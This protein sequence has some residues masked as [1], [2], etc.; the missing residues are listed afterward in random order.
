M[1]GQRDTYCARTADVS[2]AYSDKHWWCRLTGFIP[3]GEI[4]AVHG[5]LRGGG[6]ISQPSTWARE[7]DPEAG[8]ADTGTFIDAMLGLGVAVFEIEYPNLPTTLAESRHFPTL[9]LP[10]TWR[11]V[12][13]AF[14]FMQA[15]ATNGRITGS[16]SITLPTEPGRYVA[17]G[18]SE[19]ALLAAQ[20]ALAP[21]GL[22]GYD[23]TYHQSPMG[24]YAPRASG[25]IAGAICHDLPADF[26]IYDKSISGDGIQHFGVSERFYTDSINN[27][28][29]LP[30]VVRWEGVSREAKRDAGILEVIRA[31]AMENRSVGLLLNCSGSTVE[32]SY[33]NSGLT[34]SITG[35][36]T[37]NLTGAT[38]VSLT[39]TPTKT[40]TIKLIHTTE[41]GAL[42]VYA[43][44]GSTTNLAD[45]TGDLTFSTGAT[46][47]YGGGA[48]Y[49]V[50]GA[51]TRKQF[52]TRKQAVAS[53][54]DIPSYSLTATLGSDAFA[55]QPELTT[56]HPVDMGAL[57][58]YYREQVF[59]RPGRTNRDVYRLGSRYPAQISGDSPQLGYAEDEPDVIADFYRGL[60]I[61][62]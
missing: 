11:I 58:R 22:T 14:R 50:T 40:A 52:L 24:F 31:D 5:A 4:K 57:V 37:G 17:S 48:G 28:D 53:I 20:L 19:G 59:S 62:I 51:D 34:F 18:V 3:D 42:H 36:V 23:D 43:E 55:E 35:S 2:V 44:P 7:F 33:L 41:G 32:G 25:R 47:A 21:R 8:V 61:P 9:R 30:A 26:R 13:D 49:T 1:P 29:I 56:P 15:N 27:E 39:A 38:S 54:L 12:L 10:H 16:R 60:G 6:G 46:V 45:W